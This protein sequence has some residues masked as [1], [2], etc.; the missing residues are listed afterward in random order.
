MPSS[1]DT[2]TIVRLTRIE[3]KVDT[4]LHSRTDQE[5]RIR[6]LERW[7][8]VVVGAGLMVGAGFGILVRFLTA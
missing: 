2:E 3:E 7:R 6:S 5:T 1:P 4:L 8:G